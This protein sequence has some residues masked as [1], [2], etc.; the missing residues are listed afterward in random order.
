MSDRISQ[1]LIRLFQKY[2]IVF[3]YD[4]HRELREQHNSLKY[5]KLNRQ[6]TVFLRSWKDN[7]QHKYPWIEA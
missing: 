7:R 4:A 1:A 2:R 3:W 6:A 5:P